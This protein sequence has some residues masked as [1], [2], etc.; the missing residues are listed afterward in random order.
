[1]FSQKLLAPCPV[2]AVII[3]CFVLHDLI[4]QTYNLFLLHD[5]EVSHRINGLLSLSMDQS[6]PSPSKRKAFSTLKRESKEMVA[7]RFMGD[8]LLCSSKNCSFP[9]CWFTVFGA[10]L[11]LGIMPYK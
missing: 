1:M 5:K 11:N 10:F 8:N 2:S 6:F 3:V 4:G 9:R 7:R